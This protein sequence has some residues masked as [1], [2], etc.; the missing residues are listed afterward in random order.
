MS[1]EMVLTKEEKK[2]MCKAK[3]K[4]IFKLIGI[5][6]G[7][8]AVA[9]GAGFLLGNKRGEDHMAAEILCS[10][11]V[12]V[13]SSRAARL[14]VNEALINIFNIAKSQ[15]EDGFVTEY[16]YNDG[17]TEYLSYKVLGEAPEWFTEPQTTK[18]KNE[19]FYH[20]PTWDEV[21]K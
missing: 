17:K 1:E 2:A 18:V 7:I 14:A 19:D 11:G 10:D 15:G 5:G 6:L 3:R 16:K 12:K 9:G 20:V 4:K 13:I 21:T 8:G